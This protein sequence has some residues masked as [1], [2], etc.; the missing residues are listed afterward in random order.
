MTRNNKRENRADSAKTFRTNIASINK[1]VIKSTSNIKKLGKRD[2]E[3]STA[4]AERQLPPPDPAALAAALAMLL[5]EI[6]G[7]LNMIVAAL[8]LREYFSVRYIFCM[9]TDESAATLAL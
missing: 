6:G 4:L 2:L 7:A 3:S 9:L 1:L 5:M 8:G